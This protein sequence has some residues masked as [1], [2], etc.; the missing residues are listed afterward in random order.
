MQ[1]GGRDL[2]LCDRDAARAV[3]QAGAEAPSRNSS[4][5]MGGEWSARTL[6]YRLGETQT[7]SSTPLVL[8]LGDLFHDLFRECL[9]IT[10][11]ARRDNALIGNDF[12]ILPLATRIGD[13]SFDGLVRCGAP[14]LDYAGLDEQPR[15][16]ADCRD[17]L[18]LIIEGPDELQGLLVDTQQVGIDLASWEDDR[19]VVLW[20]CLVECDVDLN[21]PAPVLFVPAA[22]SP[23]SGETMWTVAPCS[24][25]RSRGTSSS[26]CSKP[27]VARRATFLP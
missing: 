2:G 19:V 6:V 8:T 5:M 23:R 7:S 12:S 25:R 10:W 20:L 13:V 18:L 14:A 11:V 15:R 17:H 22:D 9:Q 1:A 24:L 27:W 16:M 4:F 26:D 21:R 3:G